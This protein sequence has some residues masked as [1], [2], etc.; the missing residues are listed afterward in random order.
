[1]RGANGVPLNRRVPRQR[2]NLGIGGVAST[3]TSTRIRN[4]P[5]SLSRMNLEKTLLRRVGQ[6]VGDYKMIREGDHIAVGVSGGKDS[7]AL[8]DALLLLQKRSPVRYT[9]HAFTVEQGKF[10]RPIEPLAEYLKSRDI[11]WTYYRDE[12]SFQL[13]A[14]RTRLRPMQPLPP[15]RRL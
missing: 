4:R 15:P 7:L 14:A 5:R 3:R 12:A 8:L 13:R 11:P 9:L 10:L 1:M 2:Y 6:A